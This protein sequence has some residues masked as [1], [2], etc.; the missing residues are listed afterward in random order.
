M[1]HF[2]CPE[3]GERLSWTHMKILFAGGGTLGPVTPLLAVAEE[4][5]RMRPEAEC[6]FVGT[7]D[8]PERR[9]VDEMGMRF[10]ALDAPKLRRYWSL[11]TLALPFELIG[12]AWKA[13]GIL[14]AEKPD[15]IV[16]AG[17]Y[18]QVPLVLAARLRGI[19][20]L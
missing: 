5:Q 3:T 20:V 2:H 6:V 14:S 17:G 10:L 13:G 8:G 4:I 1:R 16:G 11:E 15:A 7:P 9:L 19:K 12:A 18:V